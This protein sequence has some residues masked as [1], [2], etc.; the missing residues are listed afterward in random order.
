MIYKN[1]VLHG[2]SPSQRNCD[3]RCNSR[4]MQ[5]AHTEEVARDRL[6][7]S[8]VPGMVY[9]QYRILIDHTAFPAVRVMEVPYYVMLYSPNTVCLYYMHGSCQI[10]REWSFQPGHPQQPEDG[11]TSSA[12]MQY[13]A[14]DTPGRYLYTGRTQP[15]SEMSKYEI[16]GIKYQVSNIK[17]SKYPGFNRRG[18]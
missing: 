3:T 14:N 4:C 15:T 13:L 11:C 1:G 5:G 8:H 18:Y 7:C 2:R 9:E 10:V 6:A 16:P 17:I 12:S